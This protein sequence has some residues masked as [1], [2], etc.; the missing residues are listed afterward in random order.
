MMH[1]TYP[2]SIQTIKDAMVEA[3][4]ILMNEDFYKLIREKGKFDFSNCTAAQVADTVK[5]CPLTLTVKTYKHPFGP[6][7]GK[8]FP[9]DPTGVYINV[10]PRKFNDRTVPSVVNTMIHEAIHAADSD[11]TNF[12]FDH[13]EDNSSEGKG[14]SAPYWTGCLAEMLLENPG[15]VITVKEVDVQSQIDCG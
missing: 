13:G 10:A 6:S 2:G 8:E 9:S 7:L 14:N 11:S 1:F 12:D 15:R 3:E 4:R 5:A